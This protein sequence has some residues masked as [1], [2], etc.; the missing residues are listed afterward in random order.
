MA[1]CK[2]EQEFKGNCSYHGILSVIEKNIRIYQAS[3]KRIFGKEKGKN[4]NQESKQDFTT[5]FQ[6]KLNTC[7]KAARSITSLTKKGMIS[8]RAYKPEYNGRL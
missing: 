3:K 2:E 7:A 5:K 4:L 8:L 6:E 1:T